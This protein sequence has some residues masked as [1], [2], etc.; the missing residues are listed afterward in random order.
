MRNFRVGFFP[1]L[2]NGNEVNRWPIRA[3]LSA[4][5]S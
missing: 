5:H 1:I 2:S 4:V 3:G